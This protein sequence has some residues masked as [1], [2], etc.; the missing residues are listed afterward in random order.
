MFQRRQ[1]GGEPPSQEELDSSLINKAPG[2]PSLSILSFS[3]AFHGRTMGKC[4]LLL[5]NVFIPKLTVV[6]DFVV[7]NICFLIVFYFINLVI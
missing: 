7:K 4:H 6:V 1:R 3:N 5:Q 2:C